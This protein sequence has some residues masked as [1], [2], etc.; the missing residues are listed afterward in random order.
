[1]CEPITANPPVANAHGGPATPAGKARSRR[2]A[3]EHGLTASTLFPEIFGHELL[4]RHK[5]QL[6]A[7][8][9]PSTPTEEILVAEL[10]RHA[11]ALARIEQCEG[12][13]LRNGARGVVS[14]SSA[15]DPRDPCGID[16]MLGG[17]V[18]TEAID[19]LTRY[20]RAHEKG[21]QTALLRLREA[22]AA[23]GPAERYVPL[24]DG[25]RFVAEEDCI[26][27]LIARAQR[28][29]RPCPH[30]GQRRGWPLVSRRRWLCAGC[31]RQLGLRAGTIMERSPLPLTIWFAAVRHVVR[32]RGITGQEL[33]VSIGIRRLATVR[34]IAKRIRDALDS[35][36]ATERLAGLNQVF[37]ADRCP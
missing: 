29:Q 37:Q 3:I 6:T 9:R 15:P 14:L 10:A 18:T 30:C 19:R 13:V 8:W 17:A 31:N 25:A 16:A 34:Q 11:A 7:E 26:R 5:D 21:R 23:E 22:N 35:G 1:M 36:R 27:Y 20:R 28:G 12:A 4:A 24:D 32:D 33:A 2:N